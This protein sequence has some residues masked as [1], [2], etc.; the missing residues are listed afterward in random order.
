[1]DDTLQPLLPRGNL[2][3]L[4][5]DHR[6]HK[7]ARLH[8]GNGGHQ[9]CGEDLSVAAHAGGEGSGARSHQLLCP[10]RRDRAM[11]ADHLAHAAE[12]VE[13]EP[14]RPSEARRA[15]RM[16]PVRVLLDTLPEL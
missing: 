13:T 14:R 6:W 12:G 1:E 8:E 15:L 9:G 4:L 16:H 2:R 10:A 7:Y 11:A 3:L 5:D